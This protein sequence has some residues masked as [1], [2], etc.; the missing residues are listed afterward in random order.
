MTLVNAHSVYAVGILFPIL[1]LICVALRFY[2]RKVKSIY[3]GIDDYASFLGLVF[4]TGCG[5]CCIVGAA[6]HT[7]GYHSP[8]QNTN[9]ALSESTRQF[10]IARQLEYSFILLMFPALGFI[11]L[12][13]LL[14][15]RRIFQGR[16]FDIVNW[17][18]IFLLLAWLISFSFANIFSCGIHPDAEWTSLDATEKECVNVQ[19]VSVA[20][21]VLEVAMDLF[22]IIIPIP[23]VWKL[24][25]AL[26]KKIS[27]SA[28]FA[29]GGL[30]IA[31]GIVRMVIFAEA[32]RSAVV[33]YSILGIPGTDVVGIRSLGF[34]WLQ[35]EVGISLVVSCLLPLWPLLHGPKR[36]FKNLKLSSINSYKSASN[37]VNPGLGSN[38]SRRSENFRR[39]YDPTESQ[40]QRKEDS[41]FGHDAREDF[42]DMDI[43]LQPPPPLPHEI[44]VAQSDEIGV[45]TDIFTSTEYVHRVQDPNILK[46]GES[47]P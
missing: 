24:H 5:V 43:E 13:I 10:R 15:Y 3:L 45:K 12:S 18:A 16:T 38:V 6:T 4:V 46:L 1:G 32:F 36:F 42:A 33:G 30:S 26:K 40:L 11:K 34:F 21:A 37:K 39:L 7:I 19:A 41:K 22:I 17:T 44:G 27:V 47:Q 8:K 28:I 29:I 35:V 20:G 9:A 2:V 31:A 23:F 14:F 25:L